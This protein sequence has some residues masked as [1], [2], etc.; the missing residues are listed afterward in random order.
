[1]TGTRILWSGIYNTLDGIYDTYMNTMT[2]F[3][4]GYQFVVR[5]SICDI[6]YIIEYDT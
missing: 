4:V 2:Q 6:A 5:E 1:M 3:H